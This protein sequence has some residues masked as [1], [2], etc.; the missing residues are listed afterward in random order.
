LRIQLHWMKARYN[1]A[2]KMCRYLFFKR[3]RDSF[4][5]NGFDYP[6]DEETREDIGDWLALNN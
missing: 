1:P 2:Y 4:T 5:E 3:M 6:M